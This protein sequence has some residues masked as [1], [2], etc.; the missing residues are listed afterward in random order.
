MDRISAARE[1]TYLCD[2]SVKYVKPVRAINSKGDWRIVL[3]HLKA[4]DEFISQSVRMELCQNPGQKCPKVPSECFT[5]AYV[6][7][8]YCIFF[9][10]PGCVWTKCVQKH[11]YHRLLVY[12]PTDY[13]LPFSIESFKIPSSC[14]CFSFQSE[15][16]KS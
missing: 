15:E 3:N 11:T 5:P 12:N 9:L 2:T 7:K 13:Y 10:I 8:I 16:Q 14:D 4:K 6:S 1:E